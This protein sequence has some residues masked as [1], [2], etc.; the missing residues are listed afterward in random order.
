ML[1]AIAASQI[2]AVENSSENKPYEIVCEAPAV[3]KALS[4]AIENRLKKEENLNSMED[5]KKRIFSLIR[6]FVSCQ[7]DTNSN[8]N[9]N[10]W[11]F[12]I[13]YISNLKAIRLTSLLFDNGN[14]EK[15]LTEIEKLV[16]ARMLQ[17][18]GFLKNLDVAYMHE[19]NSQ[20]VADVADL[21]VVGLIR[22]IETM[23]E[24]EEVR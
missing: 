9:K 21:I 23:M 8:I 20:S 24:D 11:F 10:G 3:T 22:T 14:L 12:N 4:L 18:R 15:E 6:I 7:Q 13:A 1:S 5:R 2:F 16:L 17:E 19:L